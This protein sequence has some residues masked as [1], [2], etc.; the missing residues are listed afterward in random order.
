MATN[1]FYEESGSFKV[2]AIMSETDASLQV[3]APHGKRSKIKSATVLLRFN[4]ALA[5][6]MPAVEALAADLDLDFLWE[7]CGEDE[8]D[9]AGLA[10]DYFGQTPSAIETAAISLRLHEAPMYFYKKGRGRYKAAP[11]ESLKAALAGQ[12]KKRLQQLQIDAWVEECRAG[13]L[14]EAWRPHLMSL[15]WKPDKNTLEWKGL[16]AACKALA[17]SPLKLVAERGGIGSVPDYL[18]AGFIM[19]HF[20]R[21]RGFPALDLPVA[22]AELPAASVEAFSI[23]DAATTEIDDALSLTRLANGN[24]QV[25]VHIAAPTLDAPRDGGLEQLVFQRLST[26]YFPGDKITM[27]PDE[28][29]GV[30][31]LNEG[32]YCPAVSVY[33]EVTPEFEIIGHESRVERVNIAA[34]LRHDWLE[35]VF[36]EETLANDTG[37]DYPYKAELTTL[38]QF[39][40]ALEVQRGKADTNATVRLDYNFAIVDGKVVLTTRRRGAPMDKL[41]SE[42]MIL[43]NSTWGGDLA[44][45]GI[46]A[47]YRAQTAGK[48]RMTTSPLPHEGLGVPQYAW[49]SSP[50]RRYVDLVNQW[51]LITLLQ[52]R[53]PHFGAK[54]DALFAAMRDF[55]LTYA[56]YAEFQRHM[57]RYWCLRWLEQKGVTEIEGT[58]RKENLVKL[59]PLPLMQRVPSL[60]ELSM[61]QRVKLSVESWDTLSLELNLRFVA[62]IESADVV[63]DVGDDEEAGA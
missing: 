1:V 28:V 29:V 33:F 3:E 8:F 38:W 19:E 4:S 59:D 20:P 18:L 62:V 35:T 30:F 55:D 56:A 16:E 22:P 48:V 27:L 32:Q 41:V 15:L 31:S 37:R 51:Q 42:L 52:D 50:L 14:P 25:G 49:S 40:N 53:A 21:G 39:A 6:F 9:A 26:V 23:D 57:E 63:A 44:A 43:A 11:E 5:D 54:S 7:C 12:E 46:P 17:L 2:G 45:A 13:R 47:M 58:V 60:P 34:N 36:N 24:W 61:G 10:A